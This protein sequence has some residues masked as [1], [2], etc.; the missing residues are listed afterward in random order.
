MG[1]IS[2]VGWFS[3]PLLPCSP[4]SWVIQGDQFLLGEEKVLG[5]VAL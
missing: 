1:I 5:S 3:K 4:S 2:S